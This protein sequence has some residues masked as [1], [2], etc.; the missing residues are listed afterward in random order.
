MFSFQ[1][2]LC[3]CQAKVKKKRKEK[4]IANYTQKLEKKNYTESVN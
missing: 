2:V 3:F 4:I 1:Y